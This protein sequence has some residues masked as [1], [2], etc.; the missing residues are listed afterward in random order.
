[1]SR[2]IPTGFQEGS[3]DVIAHGKLDWLEIGR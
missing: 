2:G 1:M 3:Y